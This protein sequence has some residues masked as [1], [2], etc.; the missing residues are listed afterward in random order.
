M[1][2]EQAQGYSHHPLM[3]SSVLM[4]DPDRRVMPA[5]IDTAIFLYSNISRYHH[6]AQLPYLW[7]HSKND[8]YPQEAA[9]SL[10]VSRRVYPVSSAA[11]PFPFPPLAQRQEFQRIPSAV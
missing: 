5:A 11:V 2:S 9:T 8:R 7:F 1:P 10:F 3:I 4:F 6:P